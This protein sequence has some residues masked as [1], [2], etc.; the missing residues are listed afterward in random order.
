LLAEPIFGTDT[1]QWTDIFAKIKHTDALWDVWRPS[2]T[3]DEMSVKDIWDCYNTVY[4]SEGHQTGLKPPL[5]LVEQ[6]FQSRW[7]KT[8]SVSFPFLFRL[9][10]SITL[11]ARKSWQRFCEIPEWID[12]EVNRSGISVADTI[13]ELEQKRKVEGKLTLM[14]MNVLSMLLASHRKQVYLCVI[15]LFSCLIYSL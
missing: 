4:S 9:L 10:S 14:S 7:R 6:H 11:Q 13:Q 12:A 5:R 15:P 8:P 3:L 2:K 1:V